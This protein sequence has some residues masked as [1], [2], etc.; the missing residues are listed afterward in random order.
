MDDSGLKNSAEVVYNYR[1]DYLVLFQYTNNTTIWG[2]L[3]GHVFLWRNINEF[4][5]IRI[6]PTLQGTLIHS[7][8]ANIN[9]IYNDL[10]KEYNCYVWTTKDED[11]YKYN[12]P[13]ICTCVT[14]VKRM[15]GIR[16][17]WI[18]TPRQLEKYL[19]KNGG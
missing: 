16:K 15:L 2:K 4:N 12:I 7:F 8:K 5:S 1:Y 13:L 6:N 14:T 19:I 10:Q 3:F 17:W 9:L 18:V 11:F